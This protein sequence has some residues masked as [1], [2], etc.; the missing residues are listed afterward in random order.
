MDRSK[1]TYGQSFA[2]YALSEY[3]MASGDQRALEMA[4]ETFKSLSSLAAD[5]VHGGFR[6]F[7][8][9]DWS[10]KQPGVYG[11]DRKSLDVHMHLM[12]AFTNLYEATGG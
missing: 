7:M 1:L 10:A 4:M 3:A 2:I 9:E 11:G 6:E 12:E 8:E 5:P